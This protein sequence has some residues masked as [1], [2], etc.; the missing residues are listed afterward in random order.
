MRAAFEDT[1]YP[2]SMEVVAEE[3][4][5]LGFALRN[6]PPGR[7]QVRDI[8]ADGF[9]AE[10]GIQTGDWLTAVNG[11]ELEHMAADVFFTHLHRRPVRLFFERQGDLKHT[12]E[13]HVVALTLRL[14]CSLRNSIVDGVEPGRFADLQGIRVGDQL[15][16]ING[17]LVRTLAS[18]TCLSQLLNERPLHLLFQTAGLERPRQQQQQQHGLQQMRQQQQEQN[19]EATQPPELQSQQSV[20]RNLLA[21]ES[22]GSLGFALSLGD[23]PLLSVL[24]VTPNSLAANQGI[25]VGDRL[26]RINDVEVEFLEDLDFREAMSIRPL[27]LQFLPA[28]ETVGFANAD[29]PVLGIDGVEQCVADANESGDGQMEA[30]ILCCI[31]PKNTLL[32]PC[33]HVST[34]FKCAEKLQVLS[35]R[36]CPICRSHIQAVYRVYN[37]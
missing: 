9:V 17:Q 13:L 26:V 20:F 15:V 12:K 21:Q 24:R 28:S 32:A 6:P 29:E 16:E 31:A 2:M 1:A 10:F 7:Q 25:D 33:G 19:L 3:A 8:K 5:V 34:C 4:R 11:M 36:E 30:C 37:S 14:G 27:R 23:F 22:D 18:S 35:T